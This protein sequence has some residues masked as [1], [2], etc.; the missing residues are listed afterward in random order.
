MRCVSNGTPIKNKRLQN[1]NDGTI[2]DLDTSLVWQRCSAGLTNLTTCT[3]GTELITDWPGA[4]NYCQSL[5]LAGK[6]WRL[7]NATELRSLIDFY[8]TYGRPGFDP[9]YFPNTAVAVAPAVANYWTSSSG[10]TS[11]A[12]AFVVNFQY[13]GGGPD[14]KSND[15]DNRTRCVSDF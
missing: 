7:P 10:T 11:G 12:T 5:N 9:I 14:V 4:I 3:G 6:T 1:N 2:L 8:I 13:S 15:D